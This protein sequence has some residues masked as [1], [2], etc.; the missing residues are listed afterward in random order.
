VETKLR[1]RASLSKAASA[2]TT[3]PQR[4]QT[5]IGDIRDGRI[6][7]QSEILEQVGDALAPGDAQKA[8]QFLDL[9]QGP[10][11]EI[12]KRSVS[13]LN[14]VITGGLGAQIAGKS[15]PEMSKAFQAAYMDLMDSIDKAREDGKDVRDL[16]TPG[17]KD[18][19][20][21][22]LV[23]RYQPTA[24]EVLRSRAEQMGSSFQNKTQS[25]AGVSNAGDPTY[26]KPENALPGT[27]WVEKEKVW[28]APLPGGKTWKYTSPTS[29]S[30]KT[31]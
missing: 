5:I 16:L 22:K 31:E 30:E 29:S 26:P 23:I 27:V 28:A 1:L 21:D 13:T 6:T 8:V 25:E 3:D 9:K 2:W 18:Y 24:Q 11:G 15:S 4:F 12:I 7:R 14:D 19:L 17:T 20:L 10:E